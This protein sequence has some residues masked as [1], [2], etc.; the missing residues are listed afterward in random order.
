MNLLVDI[1]SWKIKGSSLLL[2]LNF[3]SE[4]ISMMKEAILNKLLF[5]FGPIGWYFETGVLEF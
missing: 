2:P 3:I 1:V 5:Y 4:G